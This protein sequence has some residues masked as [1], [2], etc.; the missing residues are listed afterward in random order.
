MSDADDTTKLIMSPESVVNAFLTVAR[1]RGTSVYLVYGYAAD[2][3]AII[4]SASNVSRE[5]TDGLRRTL[6]GIDEIGVASAA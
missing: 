1:E 3:L 2:G 5:R 4:K 6:L